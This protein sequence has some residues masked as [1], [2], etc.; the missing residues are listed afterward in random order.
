LSFSIQ[1]P[2]GIKQSEK[3]NRQRRY[4]LRNRNQLLL[5]GTKTNKRLGR[6]HE[7]L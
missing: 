1:D 5:V 4:Q 2:A 6:C 3:S 7:V